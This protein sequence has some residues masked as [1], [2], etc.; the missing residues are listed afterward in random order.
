MPKARRDVDASGASADLPDVLQFMQLLWAV[1]HG[2]ERLSKRMA[3]DIGVTG[4]QR[5]VLRVV[6]LVPGMS[7]GDLAAVLH[8]HPSTLTGVLQRLVGR[9]L[10]TRPDDPADRRRAVLRLTS[11]GDRV[12]AAPEGTVEAAIALALEGIGDRDRLATR[13]VLERLAVHLEPDGPALARRRGVRG[14]S[15]ERRGVT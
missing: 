13:R 12:N 14:R 8:V 2:L 7:A 15:A 9:R 10:L 6:G 11:R 5:L 3:G 1:V 4:P